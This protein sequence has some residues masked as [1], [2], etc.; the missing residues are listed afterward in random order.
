MS[1]SNKIGSNRKYW[2]RL[3]ARIDQDI[4]EV[5]RKREEKPRRVNGRGIVRS[6]GSN[7]EGEP[8]VAEEK[9]PAQILAESRNIGYSSR[10]TYDEMGPRSA[11]YKG[12]ANRFR[13]TRYN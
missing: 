1:R 7:W 5:A 13:V 9:T 3:C 6:V 10:K 4:E 12:I 8:V 11:G 2:D